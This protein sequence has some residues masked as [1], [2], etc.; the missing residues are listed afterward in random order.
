MRRLADQALRP[1]NEDGTCRTLR[2]PNGR[3]EPHGSPPLPRA[4]HPVLGRYYAGSRGRAPFVDWLFDATAPRYELVCRL[5]SFGSGAWYRRS[6]LRR[7]GLAEGMTLLDIGAGTGLV[8]RAALDILRR[9]GSV[10]GLD[11]SAG[12]LREARKALAVPLVQ[13]RGEHLPFRDDRFHMLTI[14][15]ALRHLPDL[16]GAF[17]ECLR[18]LKPGG[19]LLVLEISRPS[20]A[21]R[22]WLLR[23]YLRRI[24]PLI[25]TVQ[26]GRGEVGLLTR[27]YWDTIEHC[28]SAPTIVKC[29]ELAGFARVEHRLYGGC[30]SEYVGVKPAARMRP[31]RRATRSRRRVPSSGAPG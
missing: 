8:A 18:V 13:G 7:A 10:I 17:A 14:A 29:L 5:L 21:V 9:S 24:L 15:Y 12:M 4:P 27:Y 30:I 3:V 22:R 20:G 25:A 23:S 31:R 1:S 28:V 11:P 2:R 6:A 16:R 26:E 19:S